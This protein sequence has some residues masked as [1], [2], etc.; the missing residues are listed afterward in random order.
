MSLRRSAFQVFVAVTL[1]IVLTG[2]GSGGGHPTPAPVTTTTTLSVS[3]TSNVSTSTP[4][5]L[6]ATVSATVG[7]ATGSVTFLDGTTTVGTATLTSGTA[8]VTL[9]TLTAGSHSFTARYAG[10]GAHSGSSASAVSLSVAAP[11][12]TTTATLTLA[13]DTN[14]TT[15]TPVTLAATITSSSGTPTGTVTFLDG[16]TTVGTATLSSGTASVAI[17]TLTAGSHSFTVSYAGDSGF[18]ASTSTAVALTVTAPIAATTTALTLSPTS[19]VTTATPVTLTATVSSSAGT[20]TGTVTFLDGTKNLGTANLASG[21][22][23][24]TISTPTAGSHSFTASYTGTSSFATSVSSAVTLTVIAATTT[25]LAVAPNTGVTDTTPLTLTATITS[26]AGTPTGRVTFLDGTN[27][28]GTANLA[29]G[30]ATLNLFTLAAGSHSL[31]A[32][33]A[34]NSSYA[35]S[36]SSALA[37]TVTSAGAINAHAAFTFTTA[38]QTISGFG[39][40]EAF[41]ASWLDQH[42]NR[43]AI[44]TALFD[45]VQGLGLNFLRVQDL[46]R[47]GAADTD[48]PKVVAAA[49]TAHGSPLTLLMSSWSPTA[50]LKSNGTTTG[51]GTLAQVSGAYN[52]AGFAQY[53]YNSLTAYAALGVSPDYISIQNEPDWPASYDSCLFDATEGTHAGYGKAFDAVYNQINA[54]SLAKVPKMIGPE[55]LSAG[56]SFLSLSASVSTAEISAYAHHL[57]NVSSTD[58]NPDDGLAALQGVE[59]AYPTQPKFMTEYFDAPGF[60]TAWNI[61]NAFTVAHDN[62]YIFWG[63]TW[64][65]TLDAA[66]DQAADQQGLIYIDNPFNAQSTWSFTQGW[67]YNDSYYAMKHYSY[68]IKPG[69]VRYNATVDNTD[70]RVSVYQSPDQKTTIIVALN[71]STSKTDVLALDLSSI[72]YTTSALYRSTFSQPI[73]TGERWASLGAY[74]STNGITLAPQSAVTIVLTN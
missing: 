7:G 25:T 49:N 4:V 27:N 56:S 43:A 17:S 38:N 52:Y 73:T 9:S 24:L 14:V 20:P 1:G 28:L 2:C 65:S 3:P 22:A 58:A 51:G 64:P 67:T 45:P 37:F 53:W 34:G 31:S 16:M 39:A 44:Y 54:G 46:Y 30:A 55:T 32:K 70:E 57:Y 62:A 19:N 21:I 13:P 69:Y 6:T 15:T 5:T 48:T 18:A 50:D 71:V 35:A 68:Y 41:Y 74:D 66:K 11:P 60:L 63:A 8:T 33:Y 61:H 40:A 10:D 59:T 36:N 23:T 72:T 26:S 42:P 12:A 29:S 47:N